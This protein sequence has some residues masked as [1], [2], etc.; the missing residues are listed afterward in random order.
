MTTTSD[1]DPPAYEDASSSIDVAESSVTQLNGSSSAPPTTKLWK[2]KKTKNGVNSKN[3]KKPMVP[4]PEPRKH[5]LIRKRSLTFGNPALGTYHGCVYTLDEVGQDLL[6]AS[7]PI[8]E[9]AESVERVVAMVDVPPEEVPEGVLNLAQSHRP[10]LYHVR[11]VIAEETEDFH[12]NGQAA[13]NENDKNN[14][15][16]NGQG[17]NGDNN[18]AMESLGGGQEET[19]EGAF[20]LRQNSNEPTVA[21]SSLLEVSA[22]ENA[23]SILAADDTQQQSTSNNHDIHKTENGVKESQQQDNHTS[24]S[25]NH[26]HK[27][28]R[29]S[30]TRSYLVLLELCSVDAAEAFVEDLH[31]KPYTSLDPT[32]KCSVHQVLALTGEDGVS[33]L[34]PFFAPPAKTATKVAKPSNSSKISVPP[35]PIVEDYNCAVCLEHINFTE[36]DDNAGESSS[37]PSSI[38]TTVC[39]HTF[40]LNCLLQWQDSPCPVCRY[41]HSGLNEALSQCNVCGRTEHNYVCLI[42]GV[43]SC[44]GPPIRNTTPGTTDS[45]ADNALEQR[46]CGMASSSSPRQQ[47]EQLPPID[48]SRQLSQSHARK[49]Y[50]DTLHAYALDTDTQHVWDFAGQGY[51]HRLL[52]NKE[53]GK[54][55]EVHDPTNLSSN[56]RSLNPGLSDTQEGE[57]VHRKLEGFASQYYTLLKSQLEQQRTYYQG[58]LQ[59]LR[60]ESL[61]RKKAQTS[62]LIHALKQEKAQLSRRLGSL[63]TRH[64]KVVDDI[65]FLKNMNESLEANKEPFKRKVRDAQ[66]QRN[67]ARDQIQQCIPVLEEKVTQLMLQLTGETAFEEDGAA[68][69]V[70]ASAAATGTTN[71]KTL[72]HSDSSQSDDRKPAARR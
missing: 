6:G 32:Q 64:N 46:M 4:P 70:D 17:I 62:D 20:H 67:D 35:A 48:N 11:I 36:E 19:K 69:N 23:A 5:S 22:A 63:K 45:S 71:P 43:V 61:M 54:L 13:N 68:S 12:M 66:R 49:H 58:R 33:L 53:D 28:S 47:Q 52:Q 14:H 27:N 18:K 40:H 51:V 38:L 29:V 44:G 60:R 15:H 1:E 34:S 9:G 57:V 31:G 72:K 7:R 65:A 8:I 50:D 39:N 59:E 26:H 37:T 56:E 25:N 2:K 30:S 3:N 10:F 41:D 42:C 24:D 55:V 21:T 16:K